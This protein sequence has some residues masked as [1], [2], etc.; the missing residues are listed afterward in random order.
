M[1]MR[2]A[3]QDGDGAITREELTTAMEQFQQRMQGGGF[4]GPGGGGPGFGG[5]GG[6]DDAGRRIMSYD[7]N[8]D[9]KITLDEAPDSEQARGILRQADED[10][11]GEVDAK[12]MEQFSRRMGGRMRG[13][14][15]GQG[16]GG[17]GGRSARGDAEAGDEGGARTE[18]RSRRG[19]DEEN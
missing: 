17:Q 4:G 6:G 11:N 5:R 8:G 12:E 14:F 10:G 19:Q 15:G 9:G 3:D 1:M 16:P 7:K 13:A 18:R 2:N